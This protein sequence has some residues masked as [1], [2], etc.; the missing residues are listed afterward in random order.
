MKSTEKLRCVI[1]SIVASGNR[2]DNLDL[3]PSL[4]QQK[5]SA[6]NGHKTSQ[7]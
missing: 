2:Y 3:M 7:L 5:I 6:F 4:Q 1:A